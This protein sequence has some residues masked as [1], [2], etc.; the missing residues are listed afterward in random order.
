MGAARGSVGIG[1]VEQWT[2]VVL[3]VETLRAIERDEFHGDAVMMFLMQWPGWAY[4]KDM[5]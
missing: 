4:E 2:R 5:S 3:T 1:I